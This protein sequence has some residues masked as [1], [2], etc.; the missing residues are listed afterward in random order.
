[1]IVKDLVV[2][3]GNKCFLDWCIVCYRLINVRVGGIVVNEFVM[4]VC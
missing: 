3:I 4:E 1:M 2:L